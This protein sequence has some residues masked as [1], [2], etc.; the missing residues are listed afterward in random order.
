MQMSQPSAPHHGHEVDPHSAGIEAEEKPTVMQQVKDKVNKIKIK[1]GKKKHE[2][3]PNRE[4]DI[5]SD[6]EEMEVEE[7]GYKEDVDPNINSAPTSE[8]QKVSIGDA[9]KFEPEKV[10]F[11][12]VIGDVKED[13]VAP[14][15]TNPPARASEPQKVS[16]GDAEKF[17]PEKVPFGN[18][19]GDVKE[20]PVAPKSTNPPARASEPQK[21]SIGDAEKFEPEKVPSGDVIGDVEEDP[22][23][24][25]ST[26]PPARGGEDIG[27]TPVI[28]SFEAIS[29]SNEAKPKLEPKPELES[30]PETQPSAPTGSTDQ[31]TVT[32]TEKLRSMA[33][34]E[35]GKNIASTVYD[36]LSTAGTAVVQKIRGGSPTKEVNTETNRDVSQDKGGSVKEYVSDKLKPGEEDQALSEVISEAVQG[37]KEDTTKKAQAMAGGTRMVERICGAVTSVVGGGDKSNKTTVASDLQQE[38]GSNEA[39]EPRMRE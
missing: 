13:P 29:V 33:T 35:Y 28:Q 1:M 34:A 30:K 7:D 6:E 15:S 11:G 27:M 26:N 38:K 36:T 31:P 39:D 37:S 19:I 16:I 14:K 5:I 4:S 32:Y 18:V 23:V 3:G 20:D 25:K 17:E 10:P 8:Q 21:V 9:E 12:N 22:A 2:D 24:P